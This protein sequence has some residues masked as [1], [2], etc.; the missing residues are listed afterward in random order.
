MELERRDKIFAAMAPKEVGAGSVGDSG[1]SLDDEPTRTAQRP[2]WMSRNPGVA[3]EVIKDVINFQ[4]ESF[5]NAQNFKA[6]SEY[7]S[8]NPEMLTNRIVAHI[9]YVFEIKELQGM[10]PGMN[11]IYLFVQEAKNFFTALRQLF[12]MDN[13][14]NSVI[15]SEALR[16]LSYGK[17]SSRT[18]V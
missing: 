2:L 14:Q 13:A 15:I 1:E 17:E 7:V 5:Q 6:A 12:G 8:Q 9:Q 10:I 4:L 3:I 18:N 16:K 11:H